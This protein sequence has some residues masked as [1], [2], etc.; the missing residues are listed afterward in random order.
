MKP[1]KN[2]ISNCWGAGTFVCRLAI[3]AGIIVIAALYLAGCDNFVEVDPPNSQLNASEVFEEKATAHAAMVEVYARMR[4]NGLFSGTFNGMSFSMG[5]Y[6]DD[7]AYFGSMDNGFAQFFANSV[8]VNS[9]EVR[10]LFN[11]SYNQIYACNAIIIGVSN[12]VALPIADKEQILGEA[13]FT[14]ALLHFYLSG[15]YGDIPYVRTTNY[16]INSNVS[17]LPVAEVYALCLADIEQALTLLPV[18]YLS[19]SR[20]RPNK[21]AAHVLLAKIAMESADYARA[22][23][24][25]SAVLNETV[26]YQNV[27]VGQTFLKESTATIWQF[28]SGNSGFSTLEAMTFIFDLGPPTNGALSQELIQAFPTGDLRLENWTRAVSDGSETWH[29]AYKY[30]VIEGPI[31]ENSIVFRLPDMYLLRAEARARL[32]ELTT[33][34]EDLNAIRNLAGIGNTGADSQSEIIS[35]ILLQNR[36]EFFCEH[37]HRFFDL[38]RFGVIDN[39]LSQTKPGWDSHDALFPIPEA[40]ISLNP[41]LLPQNPGY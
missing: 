10:S 9:A 27:D 25:A 21:M 36:L 32:G 19:P 39:V 3:S 29:H 8:T 31:T 34:K 30:K 17:R 16:T 15:I 11:T 33:A 24:E 13:L 26:L 35:D 37:G 40:E 28:S 18:E 5:L 41:G 12:A 2:T 23:N 38:K 14:R 22:E 20:T 6:G 1:N 7:M 4:E